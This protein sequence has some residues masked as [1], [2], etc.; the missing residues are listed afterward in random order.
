MRLQAGSEAT[1]TLSWHI[2]THLKPG[3]TLPIHLASLQ[4]CFFFDMHRT[5]LSSTA[6]FSVEIVRSKERNGATDPR[7][8]KAFGPK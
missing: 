5:W 1:Q 3:G 8:G 6:T 4:S 7:D 2:E